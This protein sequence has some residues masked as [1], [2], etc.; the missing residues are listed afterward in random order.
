MDSEPSR[1]PELRQHQIR[2]APDLYKEVQFDGSGGE[3]RD[4]FYAKGVK[5]RIIVYSSLDI[6]G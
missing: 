1:L 2:S 5:D 3:L 4:S 6:K